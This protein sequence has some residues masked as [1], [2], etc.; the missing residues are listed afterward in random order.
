MIVLFFG[1]DFGLDFGIGF[2]NLKLESCDYIENYDVNV[3]IKSINDVKLKS[4]NEV[5]T[6]DE[7]KKYLTSNAAY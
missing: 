7:K 4:I 1:G 6:F 2:L 3:E 5:Q